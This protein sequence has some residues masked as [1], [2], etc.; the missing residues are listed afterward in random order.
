MHLAL[1][2]NHLLLVLWLQHSMNETKAM[3]K[4]LMSNAKCQ[5]VFALPID[6][7]FSCIVFHDK[8]LLQQLQVALL[9]VKIG[10]ADYPL[11]FVG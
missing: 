7:S 4:W 9:K 1:D 10:A 2:I 3:T 6:S 8:A 11:A 5:M